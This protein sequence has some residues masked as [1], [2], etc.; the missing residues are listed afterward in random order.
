MGNQTSTGSGSSSGTY[1]IGSLIFLIPVVIFLLWFF[2]F[3]GKNKKVHKDQ[4]KSSEAELLHEK[5]ISNIEQLKPKISEKTLFAIIGKYLPWAVKKAKTLDDAIT[6]LKKDTVN[7]RQLT[8][9]NN[10]LRKLLHE[11]KLQAQKK[12]KKAQ[13]P[14]TNYDQRHILLRKEIETKKELPEYKF[15]KK[16]I[17]D[18]LVII[19]ALK[20]KEKN[21]DKAESILRGL[22]AEVIEMPTKRADLLTQ[23]SSL[24]FD[25]KEKLV[26]KLNSPLNFNDIQK[27]QKRIDSEQKRKEREKAALLRERKRAA[28][29]KKQW[30]RSGK[31]KK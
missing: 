31:I 2:K 9:L 5:I 14:R 21:L 25:N 18:A 26:E 16:Y 20:E 3:R 1:A 4:R 22:H 8:A 27:I 6:N 17:E 13:I 7:I 23:A 28:K 30:A 24:D 19:D 29:Q 12:V 10:R 15:F 11:Y